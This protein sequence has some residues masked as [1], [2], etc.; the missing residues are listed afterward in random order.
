MSERYFVV[1]VAGTDFC[2]LIDT[3]F[4]SDMWKPYLQL[5]AKHCGNVLNIL[6]RFHVVAKGFGIR[7]VEA[8]S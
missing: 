3:L 7:T 2:Y 8:Y 4:V 6:D 1:Q 5:I